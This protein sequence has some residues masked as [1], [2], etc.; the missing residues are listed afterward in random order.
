MQLTNTTNIPNEKVRDLIRIARPPNIS[1]F[2]VMLKNYKY[3]GARGRARVWG[4]RGQYSERDADA[5][6]IRKVREFRKTRKGEMN[7]RITHNKMEESCLD[8]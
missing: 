8:F 4:A 2:D 7:E 3:A 1:N 6:A 5:Y